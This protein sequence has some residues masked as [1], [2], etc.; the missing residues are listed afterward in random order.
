MPGFVWL[1][2]FEHRSSWLHSK[3]SI[4]W[5]FFPGL[6]S[7]PLWTEP[8][9]S[10]H[11][12]EYYHLS[13]MILNVLSICNPKNNSD[14]AVMYWSITEGILSA[15]AGSFPWFGGLYM[16]VSSLCHFKWRIMMWDQYRGQ[17]IMAG[18]TP[19]TSDFLG[20]E[21]PWATKPWKNYGYPHV[22]CLSRFTLT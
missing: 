2:E 13:R 18:M 5:A 1:W 12:T 20:L 4:R 11:K 17:Q 6:M 7:L 10:L 3:C 15:H 8:G 9:L 19:Q 21:Q 22:I 16:L 14:L